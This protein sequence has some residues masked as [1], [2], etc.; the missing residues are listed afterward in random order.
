[1]RDGSMLEFDNVLHDSRFRTTRKLQFDIRGWVMGFTEI[2]GPEDQGGFKDH[3]DGVQTRWGWETTEVWT[4]EDEDG[5]G[6][7]RDEMDRGRVEDNGDGDGVG[8][9]DGAGDDGGGRV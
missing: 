4:L 7:I 3:T 2:R 1:M 9:N 6:E 5:D 8:D